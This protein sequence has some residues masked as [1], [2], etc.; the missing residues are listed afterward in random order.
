MEALKD[1]LGTEFRDVYDHFKESERKCLYIRNFFI[2]EAIQSFF[3]VVPNVDAPDTITEK[4][5]ETG[6]V[7]ESKAIVDT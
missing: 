6:S 4:E 7:T 1:A 5:E 2:K 3:D